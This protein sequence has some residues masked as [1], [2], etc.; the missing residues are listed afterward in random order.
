MVNPAQTNPYQNDV[1][2]LAPRRVALG[3][4]RQQLEDP[5]HRTALLIYGR[6]RIGKTSFLRQA[7]AAFDANTVWVDLPLADTPVVDEA[8]W[9]LTLAGAITDAVV[10]R[11]LAHHRL[12]TMQPP[13][14]DPRGWFG[15]V[16]LP[17]IFTILRGHRRLVLLL[18]DADRLLALIAAGTLPDDSA[19]FLADLLMQFGQLGL[20]LTLDSTHEA[21]IPRLRP[22]IRPDEAVRLTNLT[23][24]ECG[25]LLRE[26]VAGRYTVEPEAVAAVYQQTHG[27]P[28]L[29]QLY[30]GWLFERS[31]PVIATI[32]LDDV[33]AVT[34]SVY[35]GAGPVLRREWEALAL[36]ERLVLTAASHLVYADP[37]RPLDAPHLQ[38]WLVETDYPLDT[39]TINAALRSLTYHEWLVTRP[40][41][42]FIAGDL[43][44]KW[45]L[46]HARLT[47]L[48][49][50]TTPGRRWWLAVALLVVVVLG[51]I[52]LTRLSN[53][54]EPPPSPAADPTATLIEQPA[55]PTLEAAD[56]GSD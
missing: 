25:W 22:L 29:V 28:L 54:P 46:E 6:D 7:P 10:Q 43:R 11:N 51:V 5:A 53:L 48:L 37:L 4:L 26:P 38:A 30:G 35:L 15:S 39:T 33:R 56:S 18:D 20:V 49:P 52:L 12:A 13:G 47:E 42:V 36:N 50:S 44:Q 32:T 2:P 3:R 1:P 27:L 14:D 24:D 41:G 21:D 34:P 17:E 45:L 55:G 40:E 16:F 19:V 9:L 31:L 8:D 23:P